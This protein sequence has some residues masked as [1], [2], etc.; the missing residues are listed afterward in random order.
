MICCSWLV[1]FGA[2][3]AFTGCLWDP[4]IESLQS[5]VKNNYLIVVLL[6]FFFLS[7]FLEWGIK[8]AKEKSEDCS[9]TQDRS[10]E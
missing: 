9:L 3:L 5:C 8:T 4:F 1:R 6:F 2:S 10:Q 7:I